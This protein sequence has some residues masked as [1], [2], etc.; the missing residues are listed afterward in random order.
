M[1]RERTDRDRMM[2][3]ARTAI[4][5]RVYFEYD[6]A[7]LSAEARAT[8]DAKVPY[9]TANPGMRIRVSGH[10]DDRGSD[11]YNLTPGQRRAAA[12]KRYLVQRGIDAGRIE[13]ISLGEEQ[14]ATSGSD[15]SA[16]SQ[17]RRAEFEIT[18]GGD[19]IVL[20]NR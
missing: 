18:A 9:L 11:E 3:E 5:A 19:S 20:P 15:D 4:T 1:D 16:W 2:T 6:Q 7:E 8:L 10:T 12:A 14:P 17:N 13:V